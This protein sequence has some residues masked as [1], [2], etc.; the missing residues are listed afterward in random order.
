M[1]KHDKTISMNMMAMMVFLGHLDGYKMPNAMPEGR[2]PSLKK[3]MD[4]HNH[5]KYL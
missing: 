3:S 2:N 1:I 4:I 5:F